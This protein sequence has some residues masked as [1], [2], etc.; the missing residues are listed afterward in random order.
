MKGEVQVNL[1]M[2]NLELVGYKAVKLYQ[3]Y[4]G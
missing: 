1:L 4:S 2:K 3:R